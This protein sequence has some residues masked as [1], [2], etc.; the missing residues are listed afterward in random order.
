MKPLR[1]GVN[2]VVDLAEMLK[3]ATMHLRV[4]DESHFSNICTL[5]ICDNRIYRN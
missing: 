2:F 3:E 1:K 4:F 5:L